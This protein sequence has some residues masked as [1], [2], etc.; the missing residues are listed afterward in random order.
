MTSRV[1][2]YTRTGDKGETS[3]Y[4]GRRVSKSSQRVDS[5]GTVDELNSVIGMVVS[6]VSDKKMQTFLL[7]VQTDLFTIGAALA[8][9]K[10]D[11]SNIRSR[12]ETFEQF[13]DDLDRELPELKNF[14]LPS[15]S[16]DASL[17]H[18]AR[19][20]CRRAERKLVELAK[21]EDIDKEILVYFNRLSDV[22]FTIARFLNLKKGVKD[23]VWKG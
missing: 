19:N 4:G 16:K 22:L 5:Y 7:S 14:I 12:V 8:L 10:Q 11:L 23:T 15:G 13:I 3:L 9:A 1:K 2:I 6:F 21:I 17:V 20:V 18:F